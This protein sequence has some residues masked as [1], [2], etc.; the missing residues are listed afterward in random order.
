MRRDSFSFDRG[1]MMIEVCDS[2]PMNDQVSINI[3]F[4]A[5]NACIIAL[6]ALICLKGEMHF[7]AVWNCL[8]GC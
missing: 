5:V 6:A 1:M 7:G 2:W 8:T 3:V 4:I